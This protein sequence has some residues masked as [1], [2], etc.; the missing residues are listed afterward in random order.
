MAEIIDFKTRKKVDKPVQLGYI[1]RTKK[2][3]ALELETKVPCTCEPCI[4][5][6]LLTSK[7]V[8]ISN[9]LVLDYMEKNKNVSLY[10]GDWA[11]IVNWAALE[12]THRVL[13]NITKK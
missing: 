4:A 11:D 8:T 12:V 13:N 7:L 5:K 2:C 3:I 10:R 1:E 6:R 9:W